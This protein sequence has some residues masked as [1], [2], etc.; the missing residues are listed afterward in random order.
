[1]EQNFLFSVI[2]K[3]TWKSLKI[4]FKTIAIATNFLFGLL[5]FGLGKSFQ[6]WTRPCE[7]LRPWRLGPSDNYNDSFSDHRHTNRTL[8]L[9]LPERYLIFYISCFKMITC[10][11]RKRAH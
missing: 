4:Y 9:A 10:V 1:M 2:L 7:T 3:I 5:N 6:K 11:I 8:R